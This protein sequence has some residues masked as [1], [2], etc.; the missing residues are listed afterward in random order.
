MLNGL[1]STSTYIPLRTNKR[2]GMNVAIRPYV[3]R[4]SDS[5]VLLG[6]KFRVGY[7][8]ADDGD[9]EKA[10]VEA[11]N[12]ETRVEQLK[13]FCK[14]FSWLNQSDR[15]FST[16]VFFG[17]AAGP[18]DGAEALEAIEEKGLALEFLKRLE[19]TYEQYNDA[20]FTSIR[21][22]AAAL[23][24]AWVIQSNGLFTAKPEVVALPEGVLGQKS[25]L[26]NQAQDK[27]H[28]NVLSFT[29]KVKEL[30]QNAS[31]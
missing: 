17:F 10:K 21:K 30:K 22:A 6:G 13:D 7:T 9:Y 15:R 12:P 4:E 28:G 29:E 5:V 3:L 27:Y 18:Y 20:S 26:L 25:A 24:D 2:N 16:L 14:G 11:I 8:L 19:S 1:S 31:E 23:N